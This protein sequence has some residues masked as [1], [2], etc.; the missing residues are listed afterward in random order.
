MCSK[1]LYSVHEPILERYIQFMEL[2]LG[3]YAYYSAHWAI[4]ITLWHLP[5][6]RPLGYYHYPG[7]FATILPIGLLPL[8]WHIRHYS[9]HWAITI[10]LAYSPLFCPLGYYHYPGIFTTILPIGLLPLPWHIR[11]YSAHQ[12]ITITLI[13]HNSALEATTISTMDIIKF[14]CIIPLCYIHAK[15]H[16]AFRFDFRINR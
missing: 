12:A 11:H 4:T 2:F 3:I 15:L 5:L 16:H 9:A 7:I 10:T 1:K 6:F 8:P 13:R 14:H